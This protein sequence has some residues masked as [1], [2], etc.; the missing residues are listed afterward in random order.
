[1]TGKKLRLHR[2]GREGLHVIIA[3]DHGVSVGPLRGLENMAGLIR[4]VAAGGATG[5]VLHKGLAKALVQSETTIG[6][7]LHVS[8]ST[9][10]APD[11]N[12]KRIVASVTDSVRLGFDGVS[13]H[14]NLGSLTEARQ[15]EEL[16][17]LTSD[18]AAF[19]LPTLSM[20]Y[21][22]G[23]AVKDPYAVSIVSHA[24]R[25]AEELGADLVKT[26]YTGDAKTFREVTAGVT[27]PVLVAGGPKMETDRELLEM[28]HGAMRGG[29]GGV[30]IGRNVF[31]HKS[32]R[33]ITQAISRIVLE[34]ATAKD[35]VR[36]LKE[37][38]A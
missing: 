33:A 31:Q 23:P 17:R 15:L 7:L 24:A 27:I 12:D 22:R 37:V 34:G 20:M 10:K 19:G 4:D 36:G 6:A 21:P 5:V 2:L 25:L 11:G 30:S 16:G 35:A 26:V 18:A 1:M 13:A 28:V 9:D 3:L 32:P 29:A 38:K 14:T 8:A